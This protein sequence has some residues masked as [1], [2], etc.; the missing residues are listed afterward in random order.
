METFATQYRPQKIEEMVGQ[1]HLL[2]KNSIIN[3]FIKNNYIQSCILYG[4]PG[5]G[6]TTLARILSKELHKNFIQLNAVDLTVKDI[7]EI[8]EKDMEDTIIFI[9]EIH[10]LQK[11]TQQILLDVIESGKII[12]IGST[13]ENPYFTINKAIL[14]R[15]LIFEFKEIKKEEIKERIKNIVKKIEIDYN[16]NI[17]LESDFIDELVNTTNGDLRSCLNKLEAIFYKNKNPF[18][19]NIILQ[20]NDLKE[21]SINLNMDNKNDRYYDLASALM[22]S[23][24]GSATDAALHYLAL[25]LNL[26]NDSF[27]VIARRLLCSA[28]EDVGMANP[29]AIVIVKALV[30]TAYQLG[31]P[32]AKLHFAE[33]VIFLTNQPK[34][35]SCYVA[36][37]KAMNDVNIEEIPDYLK[38]NH[39]ANAKNL[40][41]G[42]NYKYPHDYPNNYVDQEYM[43][44][45][46]KNKKYYIYGQSYIEKEYQ[47]YWNEIKKS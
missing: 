8:I 36:I 41:H 35:N 34:S 26:G 20:T 30:D 22:K 37:Q 19:K 47:K 4:P 42:N 14:S 40:H 18:S 33:A 44:E 6:K 9:D 38:D 16:C 10:L 46:L 25:L 45:Q 17:E 1:E 43:P 27:P 15:C 5:T 11:K 12:L 31:L 2:Y 28:A 7:R 21:L 39:Y 29:N 32:E 24:R 13:A 3:S 23:L